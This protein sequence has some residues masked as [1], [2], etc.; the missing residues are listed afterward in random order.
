M[1]DSRNFVDELFIRSINHMKTDNWEWP[2]TWDTAR[3]HNFLNE[4]LTFA[5]SQE[6]YEQC[7]IIRDVK[8]TIK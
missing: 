1:E 2:D 6:M 5:E 3:K 4:S 8:E 7:S